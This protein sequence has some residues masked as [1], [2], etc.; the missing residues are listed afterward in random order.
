MPNPRAFLEAFGLF[1]GA[2]IS[3]GIK[4]RNVLNVISFT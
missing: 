3:D 1:E 2:Q 4:E